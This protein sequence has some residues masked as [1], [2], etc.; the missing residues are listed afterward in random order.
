M[1]Y[2]RNST[3]RRGIFHVYTWFDNQFQCHTYYLFRFGTTLNYDTLVSIIQFKCTSK[4]ERQG[5]KSVESGWNMHVY[6]D[7]VIVQSHDSLIFI[8]Y[9]LF[10]MCVKYGCIWATRHYLEALNMFRLPIDRHLPI[11][12]ILNILIVLPLPCTF[13]MSYAAMSFTPLIWLLITHTRA[14]Q[15]YPQ[16]ALQFWAKC[17][18]SISMIFTFSQSI[19]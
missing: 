7:K 18:C 12:S 11:K 17:R 5:Q 19:F 15:S 4:N 9:A 3:E 14:A 16:N 1:T 8:V 6:I 2:A 13:R 10:H